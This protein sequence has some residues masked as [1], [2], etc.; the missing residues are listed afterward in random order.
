M[1]IGR[2]GAIGAQATIAC[3]LIG[4][5]V[6]IHPG[7]HIGQDGFGFALGRAAI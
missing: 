7:A 1:R 3:A 5:R 2:D 4:D 6:I